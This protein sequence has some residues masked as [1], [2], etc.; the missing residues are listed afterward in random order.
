MRWT[1]GTYRIKGIE[2]IYAGSADY[3]DW[4]Y[5]RFSQTGFGSLEL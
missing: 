3:P 4:F 1:R 5:T 2:G